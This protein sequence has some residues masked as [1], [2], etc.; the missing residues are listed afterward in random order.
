MVACR[1]LV[2]REVRHLIFGEEEKQTYVMDFLKGFTTLDEVGEDSQVRKQNYK[3]ATAAE[4]ID[5]LSVILADIEKQTAKDKSSCDMIHSENNNSSITL[6]PNGCASTDVEGSRSEI[7][8]LSHADDILTQARR[9]EDDQHMISTSS[10]YLGDSVNGH[11]QSGLSTDP[12]THVIVNTRSQVCES[13][14]NF[15]LPSLG[16]DFDLEL[17]RNVGTISLAV[18]NNNIDEVTEGDEAGSS[19]LSPSSAEA[20]VDVL[21]SS[22]VGE[23]D[24]LALESGYGPARDAS[25]SCLS[26]EESTSAVNNENTASEERCAR[27][28][29]ILR[30]IHELLSS[31]SIAE[32][33][34]SIVHEGFAENLP[35]V[36]EPY[37]EYTNCYDPDTESIAC[38]ESVR[39]L[40]ESSK[41]IE[42]SPVYEESATSEE[43]FLQFSAC[44]EP[45]EQPNFCEEPFENSFAYGESCE[46]SVCE[47]SYEP[48]SACEGTFPLTTTCEEFELAAVANKNLTDSSLRIGE[49]E[50]QKL[51]DLSLVK[52]EPVD[53]DPG[54]DIDFGSFVHDPGENFSIKEELRLDE[55]MEDYS[56][57]VIPQNENVSICNVKVEEPE[58]SEPHVP[59]QRFLVKRKF[60]SKEQVTAAYLISQSTLSASIDMTMFK[61]LGKTKPVLKL[62]PLEGMIRKPEMIPFE[63]A[64][65]V[66]L[67]ANNFGSNFDEWKVKYKFRKIAGRKRATL[68]KKE[69]ASKEEKCRVKKKSSKSHEKENLSDSDFHGFDSDK[70]GKGKKVHI[71]KVL[72]NLKENALK[73]KQIKK[74]KEKIKDKVDQTSGAYKSKKRKKSVRP[75]SKEVYLDSDSSDNEPECRSN[76]KYRVNTFDCAH[77]GLKI[78]SA[79][80]GS[81]QVEKKPTK[82]SQKKER[83]KESTKDASFSVCDK[84]QPDKM[85]HIMVGEDSLALNKSKAGTVAGSI[86]GECPVESGDDYSSQDSDV[87]GDISLCKENSAVE[88]ISKGDYKKVFRG[89]HIPSEIVGEKCLGIESKI[90]H[91]KGSEI[92]PCLADSDDILKVSSGENVSSSEHPKVSKVNMK[93]S[94]KKPYSAGVSNDTKKTAVME[95]RVDAKVSDLKAELESDPVVKRDEEMDEPETELDVK[96]KEKKIKSRTIHCVEHSNWES[97]NEDRELVACVT[98]NIG[99]LIK[100][101]EDENDRSD[102]ALNKIKQDFPCETKEEEEKKKVDKCVVDE[103]GDFELRNVNCEKI[104]VESELIRNVIG[105]VCVLENKDKRQGNDEVHGDEKDVIDRTEDIVL[106]RGVSCK[107]CIVR[108]TDMILVREYQNFVKKSMKK[109]GL[110]PKVQV[111][112]LSPLKLLDSTFREERKK[113]KDKEKSK[114]QEKGKAKYYCEAEIKRKKAGEKDKRLLRDT[115]DVQTQRHPNKKADREKRQLYEE[116]RSAAKVQFPTIGTSFKI[117]KKKSSGSYLQELHHKSNVV[118]SVVTKRE[119]LRR[120]EKKTSMYASNK[121]LLM[122]RRDNCVSETEKQRGKRDT[123]KDGISPTVDR[124]RACHSDDKP[125]N[126][127]S[128]PFGPKKKSISPSLSAS[129][130]DPG[131]WISAWMKE[132]VSQGRL[133]TEKGA[134]R[135]EQTA[136]RE[137]THVDDTIHDMDYIDDND[138]DDSPTDH[139]SLASEE[140]TKERGEKPSMEEWVNNFFNKSE[141]ESKSQT[142]LLE[143]QEIQKPSLTSFISEFFGG[144]QKKNVDYDEKIHNE[145]TPD[146]DFVDCKQDKDCMDVKIKINDVNK[147]MLTVEPKDGKGKNSLIKES[148][149][150]RCD[151]DFIDSKG[152]SEKSKEESGTHG[153][154]KSGLSSGGKGS[155]SHSGSTKERELF[156]KI[157]AMEENEDKENSNIKEALVDENPLINHEKSPSHHPEKNEVPPLPQPSAATKRVVATEEIDLQN[158]PPGSANGSSQE[159]AEEKSSRTVANTESKALHCEGASV[160]AP[161]I[162]LSGITLKVPVNASKLTA[163]I[164]PTS[165]PVLAPLP[166]KYEEIDDVLNKDFALMDRRQKVK[167]YEKRKRTYYEAKKNFVTAKG[168]LSHHLKRA[169][170]EECERLKKEFYDLKMH[171][172]EEKKR[173]DARKKEEFVKKK[174]DDHETH[175]L[176]KADKVRGIYDPETAPLLRLSPDPEDVDAPYSPTGS[177]VLDDVVFQIN[178]R[179]S[180]LDEEEALRNSLSKSEMVQ[181]GT[182]EALPSEN[183]NNLQSMIVD[184]LENIKKIPAADASGKLTCHSLTQE[185]IKKIKSKANLATE[186]L[187]SNEKRLRKNTEKPTEKPKSKE[188]LIEKP[189]NTEKPTEKPLGLPNSNDPVI[190]IASLLSKPSS[191]TVTSTT[192]ITTVAKTSF[193]SVVTSLPASVANTSVSQPHPAPPPV[194]TDTT[195]CIPLPGSSDPTPLLPPSESLRPT[196]VPSPVR[197]TSKI[198]SP[199]L[200][201]IAPVIR[202]STNDVPSPVLPPLPPEAPPPPLPE[203]FI[204]PLPPLPPPLPPEDSTSI[205]PPPL[206]PSSVVMTHSVVNTSLPL[207][208]IPPLTLSFSTDGSSLH[209]V[210]GNESTVVVPALKPPP[211]PPI[212][213][214]ISDKLDAV[215]M[216][217]ESDL[218][219][220][221]EEDKD[222]V[223]KEEVSKSKN[224][225]EKEGDARTDDDLN[226]L[227][228]FG[229]YLDSGHCERKDIDER[230]LESFG[231]KLSKIEEAPSLSDV[232]NEY[233]SERKLEESP[234]K[235]VLE[236]LN[237]SLSDTEKGE[238]IRS[239]ATSHSSTPSEASRTSKLSSNIQPFNLG[240]NSHKQENAPK[241]FSEDEILE[242]V[243]GA[244]VTTDLEVIFSDVKRKKKPGDESVSYYQKTTL[245][246]SLIDQCKDIPL[247]GLQYVLEVRQNARTTLD[248]AYYICAL[249]SKKMNAHTLLAHIKSVPHRLK[250]A[251]IHCREVFSKFGCITLKQ[252]TAGLVKE[253]TDALTDVERK[254]GRHKLAVAYERDISAALASLKSKIED[255]TELRYVIVFHEDSAISLLY[256]QVCVILPV[257]N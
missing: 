196:P 82:P 50:S 73:K 178:T 207:A 93:S 191:V 10:H 177:P 131:G 203:K 45:F 3:P 13:D 30:G 185:E 199:L 25:C 198:I 146:E 142:K 144:E 127:K 107:S 148:G 76:K 87:P 134:W 20:S 61:N 4:E 47:E 249:C 205:P 88:N 118:A 158:A 110:K 190:S 222:L 120:S 159:C 172:Y 161:V 27:P 245:A 92:K 21:N 81:T 17:H 39:L 133:V 74:D 195:S 85:Q 129:S 143:L 189:K 122:S 250:F 55:E 220:E 33:D 111:E 57:A 31:A 84:A 241:L 28:N 255:I 211:L 174:K 184:L 152:S 95:L 24:E 135:K 201:A 164:N 90:E 99:N 194:T 237:D 36:E 19:E 53:R 209:S 80:E 175:R 42:R 64:H 154:L 200:P 247:V 169:K 153:E 137:F 75:T 165:T 155:S 156:M 101:L 14:G 29:I 104:T 7:C 128:E 206:P 62:Y 244:D 40:P 63:D 94:E 179:S 257:R 221:S 217:L 173:E 231:V 12:T 233:L 202:T 96:R 235:N 15:S 168:E 130:P 240:D 176:A 197:L 227:A 238:G 256:H 8:K 171:L 60:Y 234:L 108:L 1:L 225:T 166:E 91:N 119:D 5:Y 242:I 35:S 187:Q 67:F 51:L 58:P 117:P 182:S 132:E 150:G 157:L 252:W 126:W 215:P 139:Y 254:L 181:K 34:S 223:V 204:P 83:S 147:V 105:K 124:Y 212:I 115:E 123:T 18:L 65:Y 214:S 22:G 170:F 103:S 239:G 121:S 114:K 251:E 253:F 89:Q 106:P 32:E 112:S 188:K 68:D 100:T 46:S 41:L 59:E 48:P 163:K 232:L 192:V 236:C 49:E 141:K 2:D 86:I 183:R 38:K 97:D 26:G 113:S 78:T 208:A 243:K 162:A 216:D 160:K 37:Q 23:N 9:R 52:V 6:K 218:E 125:S 72:I 229:V 213:P 136:T 167:L 116:E 44:E 98:Q 210:K 140:S 246:K 228:S 193:V 138:G 230:Y 79:N 43:P 56:T 224:R 11:V 145:R 69:K 186:A 16:A 109:L 219:Y 151:R 180:L 54:E 226:F 248:D 77:D 70:I 102:I 66:Q 149:E 71:S